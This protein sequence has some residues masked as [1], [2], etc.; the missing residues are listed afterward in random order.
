MKI[1]LFK[2]KVS[3]SSLVKKVLNKNWYRSYDLT[4][5]QKKDP[6]KHYLEEGA[7]HGLDPLP[8]FS[9]T[10][11]LEKY[12]DVASENLNPLSHYMRHGWKEGRNPHPLFHTRFYLDRYLSKGNNAIN[13]LVHYVK[14]GA[15]RNYSTHPLLDIEYFL[16]LH[17]K[18]SQT[19]IQHFLQVVKRD[20]HPLFDDNWYAS[21]KTKS[22][23]DVPLIDYI[24]QVDP[25]ASPNPFFDNIWYA[26]KFGTKIGRENPPLSH[27]ILS[28]AKEGLQPHP[29]FDCDWYLQKNIDV[30]LAVKSDTISAY[31]HFVKSGANENR[32]FHPL[33]TVD[34]SESI[35]IDSNRKG[36][37]LFWDL[38]ENNIKPD[39]GLHLLFD[40]MYY[41]SSNPDITSVG[42]NP[43]LHYLRTGADEGR[44]PHPLFKTSYYTENNPD[45]QS[46]GMNPLVHY[47]RSGGIEG[48][49]PH[50]LFDVKYYLSQTM[51][52]LSGVNPLVHFLQTG[53]MLGYDPNRFFWS[54]WYKEQYEGNLEDSNPLI[55][56]VLHGRSEERDPSPLFDRE[57]YLAR[58]SDIRQ[59]DLDPLEHFLRSGM[60]EGRPPRRPDLYIDRCR[61][62]EMPVEIVRLPKNLRGKS[63]CLFAAFSFSILSESS[64]R[65]ALDALQTNGYV[66]IVVLM[67]NGDDA[68]SLDK[69]GS[70]DG[71]IIRGNHGWEFAAWA[72]GFTLLPALWQ[73]QSVILMTDS[74]CGT[75][76]HLSFDYLNQKMSSTG[77]DIFTLTAAEHGNKN[78]V[79]LLSGIT[80]LGLASKPVQD[81][82]SK[83]ESIKDRTEATAKF[84]TSLAEFQRAKLLQVESFCFEQFSHISEDSYIT[85]KPPQLKNFTSSAIDAPL[86]KPAL[87]HRART[88]A[89]NGDFIDNVINHPTRR[90]HEDTASLSQSSY[91][92]IPAPHRRFKRTQSQQTYYGATQSI[93]PTQT[94]DLSIEIPFRHAKQL[95][96]TNEPVAVI[97]HIFYPELSSELLAYFSNIPLQA[98]LFLTTDCIEKKASIELAFKDY[99][100]GLIEVRV[101]PNIGRDIAPTIVGCRDVFERYKIFLHVHSKKSPHSGKFADWR[102]YLL[103]NLLGSQEKIVSILR[104]LAA[105]D[106]GIVFAEHFPAVRN[107]LNWGYDFDFAKDLLGRTG[108]SLTRD[109]VLEFPSSSFFWGR[110]EALRELLNLKLDWSDFPDE[111]GQIDGTIMHA[112]ERSILY[113]AERSGYRWCKVSS[114]PY[115]LPETSM[116]VHDESEVELCLNRVFRPLL[117]N[118]I[119]PV[120]YNQLFAEVSPFSVCPSPV[121][122]PRL[123]LLIPTLNPG[124]IFGGITTALRVFSSLGD[125][126]ENFERR[127]IVCNS[128]VDLASMRVVPEYVLQQLGDPNDGIPWTVNDLSD[129]YIGNFSLRSNDIFLATAW[130]TADTSYMLQARQGHH[131]GTAH[132]I[133]YLIQDFEPGFYPWSDRFGRSIATYHD[134]SNTIALINSEELAEFLSTR[135]HFTNASVVRYKTHPSIL[136]NLKEAPRER[137][138]LFYGRPSVDRNCF[139]TICGALYKWQ[140]SEPVLSHKWTI[141]SAGE[142]YSTNSA[143]GVNNIRVVGKMDLNEYADILSRA[144]VGISLMMSPHPS[145]PPLEMAHSGLLTI[146]NNYENKDLSLRSNNIV[147]ID[148][149]TPDSLFIALTNCISKAEAR[150]G[151]ICSIQEIKDL[152]CQIPEYDPKSLSVD[153]KRRV[154]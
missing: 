129:G 133:I 47:V 17:P 46:S 142:D 73:A 4:A 60:T 113:F 114:R 12:P 50:P 90:L 3:D 150:I 76:E 30:A 55:H 8:L 86:A 80:T 32:P 9:T 43:L 132:P 147:S 75:V 93:R 13:P 26:R 121:G 34:Y 1:N 104:L 96:T 15:S 84:Q 103:D 21:S 127:I 31:T 135:Y 112:I 11:Y 53:A 137:I 24:N 123:N 152:P 63:V 98:D 143:V 40:A 78:I 115:N 128:S 149:V 10:W 126:C 117:G 136:Q 100:N 42:I 70:L 5:E 130:W 124:Q 20:S 57:Y 33:V 29:L 141:V 144:S 41:L 99:A 6:V 83:V 69:L 81:F 107:L 49:R 91:R 108:V 101:Y 2:S 148:S 51:D 35:C 109:M 82:W 87:K 18:G 119:Y 85:C 62:C 118:P 48:R 105:D 27:Y 79:H 68:C 74:M 125:L 77:Y 102:K 22:V 39:T 92:P 14:I 65:C 38:M 59:F 146:T 153:L 28:G 154:S 88:A 72:A 7:K 120:A 36:Q 122:R 23:D 140:Q 19:P 52:D 145:Y 67:T 56:Y 89:D 66:V 16:S 151:T 37:S 45:V 94:T 54:T 97:A 71:L 138:I 61:V 64:I 58:N 111:E 131:F 110:S 139:Q 134:L 25:S 95:G 116:I 106:V 44:N